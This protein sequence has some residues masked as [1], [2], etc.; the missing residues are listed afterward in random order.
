MAWQAAPVALAAMLGGLVQDGWAT[1]FAVLYGGAAALLNSGLLWWRWRRGSRRI[2]SDP[3]QH[4][5]SFHRSSL[6]RFFVVGMWLSVGFTIPGLQP[7]PLLS[8]FVVGQ[9]AMIV[10]GAVQRE[11]T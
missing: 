11:R 9:L 10:A 3:E 2:H 8:G 7:L 4:L 6:E 5:K 1:A